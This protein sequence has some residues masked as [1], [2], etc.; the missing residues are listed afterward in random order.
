MRAMTEQDWWALTDPGTRLSAFPRPVSR[1][2]DRLFAVGCCYHIWGILEDKRSRRAV[3][4]A[5]QYADGE[6][7]EEQLAAAHADAGD[8]AVDA[9]TVE[10]R[11]A[12]Q[13]AEA[14]SDPDEDLG[15]LTS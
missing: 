10:A 13:A 9:G 5:E 12:A 3:R 1:R 15:C 8:A 6:A 14:A 4:V 2:K 11:D 7:S